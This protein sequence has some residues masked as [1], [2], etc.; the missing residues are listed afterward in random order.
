MPLLCSIYRCTR[1][2]LLKNYKINLLHMV[3]NSINYQM[4]LNQPHFLYLFH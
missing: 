4:V 3:K 2:I 1:E